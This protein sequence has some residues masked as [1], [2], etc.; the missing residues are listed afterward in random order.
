MQLPSCDSDTDAHCVGEGAD[1]SSEGITACLEGLGDK[2]SERCSNFLAL[3]K[4]CAADLK[5]D[6]ACASAAM[7]GEGVPCLIQR[8][9]PEQLTEA[10]QS[11]LPKDDL[12]GARAFAFESE[13]A[14]FARAQRSAVHV[15][16]QGW[17]SFGRTASASSTSTRS[18]T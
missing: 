13:T 1:L 15:V 2:R 17:Q 10:C 7:D 3:T 6:G 12:K 4:A 8:V 9:K 16:A 5:G 18:Q 11:A 14:G